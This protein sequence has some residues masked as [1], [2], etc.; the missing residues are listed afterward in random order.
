MRQRIAEHMVL[1]R[2]TSAHVTS[3]FEVDMTGVRALK[4]SL[5]AEFEERHRTRLTYLPFIVQAT[6]RALLRFPLLNASVEGKNIHCHGDVNMGIAVALDD[7][8]I[9]P[10]IRKAHGKGILSLAK[11]VN[12]LALRARSKQLKPEEVQGGT[13]TITNPGVFGSLIGTPIINQP[14]VGILC[15]GAI[16]KRPVVLS[17]TDAIAIRSMAYLSLT[18]DHRLVDGAVADR[19]LAE[20]KSTLEGTSFLDIAS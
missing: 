5:L 4:D 7:G 17:D 20:V 9:V 13:F 19:F 10:V 3:V 1:S 8:L 15:V 11:A 14:Q 12:D 2:K 6:A 16:Q 18:F